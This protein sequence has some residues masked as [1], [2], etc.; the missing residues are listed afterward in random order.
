MNLHRAFAD[1][2]VDVLQDVL[3]VLPGAVALPS[4]PDEDD[5]SG[6]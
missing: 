1:G 3:L 4:V 6:G 2:H 5:V